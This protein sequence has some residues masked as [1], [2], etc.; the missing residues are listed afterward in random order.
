MEPVIKT[1]K[2]RNLQVEHKFFIGKFSRENGTTS[3]EIPFIPENFQ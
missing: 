3:S 1:V 2:T